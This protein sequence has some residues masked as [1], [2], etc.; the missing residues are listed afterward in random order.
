MEHW[1]GFL[2][3]LTEL[4]GAVQ[5]IEASLDEMAFNPS[6]LEDAEERLF[7]IRGL[8]R[9]H[10]VSPDAVPQLAQDSAHKARPVGSE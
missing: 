3:H 10:Q 8:A 7:A 4:D 2:G 1:L 6:D 5:Q 9:K